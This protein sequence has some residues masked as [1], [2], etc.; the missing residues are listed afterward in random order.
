M[1]QLGQS[2]ALIILGLAIGLFISHEGHVSAA[3][4]ELPPGLVK[5]VQFNV[6]VHSGE[7][8]A[9]VE[10]LEVIETNGT[11]VHARVVQSSV[12]GKG[13]DIWVN[14]AATRFGYLNI[15]TTPGP[16]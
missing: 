12:W 15:V 7:G 13:G 8:I 10:T 4:G 14:L 1:K 2:I 16:K 3:T 5:G 9:A 11:W 6:L